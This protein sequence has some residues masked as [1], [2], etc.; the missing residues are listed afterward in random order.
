[1]DRNMFSVHDH[2]RC[3]NPANSIKSF[4]SW[5]LAT[6]MLVVLNP[7]SCLADEL[8]GCWEGRW[9]GCTDGLQGTV[10][11]QITKCNDHCYRAVFTGRAFKVMPYRYTAML[12]AH[13]D[14]ETGKICFKCTR[15]LPIW[16]CYWM[17]GSADG[18][19]FF[20]R[21]NTDDHVGYF[22]MKRVCC[23]K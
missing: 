22:K 11:A 15:K 7:S 5:L 18:C 21:Y 8:S 13:R 6:A 17:R 23:K 20:A 12:K 14:E 4:R 10:K 1:M 2:L 3:L 9:Y 16:G 19:Q